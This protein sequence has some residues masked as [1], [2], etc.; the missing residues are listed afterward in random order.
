MNRL[1]LTISSLLLA[2]SSLLHA[3]NSTI[4]YSAQDTGAALGFG[5]SELAVGSLVRFGYFD[6]SVDVAANWQNISLLNT[7]FTELAHTN[8]GYF[9]GA[10]T[11]DNTTG[12]VVSAD[13]GQNFNVPGAFAASV[14]LDASSLG[15]TTTRLYIWAYNT[16][17]ADV[18]TATGIFSDSLWTI[19]S[20]FS[21]TFDIGAVRP[22]DLG[23][24]YLAQL[25]PE[26]SAALGG[27][28]NQ[29]QAIP[30]PSSLVFSLLSLGTLTLTRRRRL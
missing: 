26:T 28:L 1:Q 24:V 11:L 6:A 4:T 15:L 30:E 20:K 8:V 29:L 10:T 16:S 13:N 22:T 27:S 18:A 17:T 14:T 5:G 7:K 12:S 21:A 3:G 25:G 2:T 19:G 23:D 9:N